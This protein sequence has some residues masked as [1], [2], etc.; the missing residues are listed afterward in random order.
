MLLGMAEGISPSKLTVTVAEK[1]DQSVTIFLVIPSHK[2]M[3]EGGYLKDSNVY[4]F[5]E[6]DG[7]IPLPQNVRAYIVAIG[8]NK[9]SP[10]LYFAR[11]SFITSE[12]QAISLTLDTLSENDIQGQI[13]GL[14]LPDFFSKVN[15]TDAPAKRQALIQEAQ[16]VQAM[17]AYC[18]CMN[19]DTGK[20]SIYPVK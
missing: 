4:G 3:I 19:T 15:K 13:A 18:D 14:Q 11:T 6:E 10:Q 12:S 2:I 7:S 9:N 20:V 8:E 17:K 1:E 5:Y 16:R